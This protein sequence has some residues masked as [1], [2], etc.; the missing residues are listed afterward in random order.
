[1]I[2]QNVCM[3]Y[4]VKMLNVNLTVMSEALNVVIQ[5]GLTHSCDFTISL[6]T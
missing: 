4:G 6:C 3:Y 2:K 1:M 5:L